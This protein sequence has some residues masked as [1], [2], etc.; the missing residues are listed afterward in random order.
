MPPELDD[1]QTDLP[2]S[3]QVN[4]VTEAAQAGEGAADPSSAPDEP[5]D[6]LSVVRDVV[7]DPEAASSAGDENA[8][9]PAEPATGE[10]VKAEKDDTDYTDVPFHKHPR[11]QEVLRKSKANEADA[12]QFRQITGFLKQ[13]HLSADEA[14]DGL[15]IMALAKTSPAKALERLKPFVQTLLRAAGE[16]LPD[17]LRTQVQQGKMPEAAAREVS[18][19][20]AMLEQERATQEMAARQRQEEAVHAQATA[21]RDAAA[22]WEQDRRVKD[23]AFQSKYPLLEREVAYLQRAEG[24]PQTPEGVRDQLN[25]AYDT[26][27]KQARVVAPATPRPAVRPVTGGTAPG[28]PAAQPKTMLEAMKRGLAGT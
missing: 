2:S 14:A 16:V 7:Q 5:K 17:D 10:Q 9:D 22:T 20:R 15:E 21:R 25:R 18:R 6:M 27:N 13:N 1:N 3:E 23:P 19:S 4:D 12:N 26:V 28:T 24:V 11:F 8:E